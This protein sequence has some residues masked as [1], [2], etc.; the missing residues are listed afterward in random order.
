MWDSIAVY[1]KTK[2]MIYLLGGMVALDEF[3]RR[4]FPY[5]TGVKRIVTETASTI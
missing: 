1:Y 2:N 4:G 3:N 5:G